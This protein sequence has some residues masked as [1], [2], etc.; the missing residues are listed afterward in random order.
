MRSAGRAAYGVDL[1]RNYSHA[2]VAGSSDRRKRYLPCAKPFSEPE[3]QAI[4]L[5]LKVTLLQ[6]F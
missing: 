4:N 3:T 6:C 5:S 2:K 1:N